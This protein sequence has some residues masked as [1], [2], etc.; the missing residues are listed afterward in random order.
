MDCRPTADEKQQHR[1]E[2]KAKIEG[3][4]S[5]VSCDCESDRSYQ[6]AHKPWLVQR[7][8]QQPDKQHKLRTKQSFREKS[9]RVDY[10]YRFNAVKKHSPGCG[11]GTRKEVFGDSPD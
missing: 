2:R 9:F 11:V 7:S 4:G 5:R 3:N 6:G 1:Y 8:N 10:A